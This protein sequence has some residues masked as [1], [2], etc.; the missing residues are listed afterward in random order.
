MDKSHLHNAVNFHTYRVAKW[1]RQKKMSKNYTPQIQLLESPRRQAQNSTEK[2]PGNL[3]CS[4]SSLEQ[5]LHLTFQSVLT[6]IEQKSHKM[7]AEQGQQQSRSISIRN[8][9][10]C[11]ASMVML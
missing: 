3:F 9:R 4:F 11:P 2:T 5:F 7:G 1:P 10:A 8:Y 6:E